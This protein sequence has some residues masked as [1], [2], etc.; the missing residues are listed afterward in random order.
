M[1]NWHQEFQ[2]NHSNLLDGQTMLVN[3]LLNQVKTKWIQTTYLAILSRTRVSVTFIKSESGIIYV[4]QDGA[5]WAIWA[6][7]TRWLWGTTGPTLFIHMVTC[8]NAVL[9]LA[10][11]RSR[12][13]ILDCDWLS[14][15]FTQRYAAILHWNV[16]ISHLYGSDI[17]AHLIT[18]LNVLIENKQKKIG[19]SSM[20]DHKRS[21]NFED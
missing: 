7:D 8:P 4:L 12:D 14:L 9:W 6:L 1:I 3:Q 5:G 17:I 2:I 20:V 11:T 19:G 13:W 18:C 10:E 21:Y 16:L 15:L